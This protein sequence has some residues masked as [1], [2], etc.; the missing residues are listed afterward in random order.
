LPYQ[1]LLDLVVV[2]ALRI[3]LRSLLTF[4]GRCRCR[5]RLLVL[6]L[7]RRT[8]LQELLCAIIPKL[9]SCSLLLSAFLWTRIGVRGL[10]GG[11]TRQR[12]NHCLSIR[13]AAYVLRG[14]SSAMHEKNGG[15]KQP[16]HFNPPSLM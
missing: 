9:S 11:G 14:T 1:F 2:M 6:S 3:G 8:L 16:L 13:C 5:C 12:L 4:S 10:G 7:L 15:E